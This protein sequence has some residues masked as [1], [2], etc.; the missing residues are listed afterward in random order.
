MRTVAIVGPTASGK[1]ALALEVAKHFD[2]ELVNCDSVQVY[3]NFDIGSAKPTLDDLSVVPHHLIDVCAWDE[4]FDAG[5][6]AN[7]AKDCIKDISSR[8]KLPIIVGGTGLYL[9][10]LLEDKFH[11]QLPKDDEL[12]KKLQLKSKDE[13]IEELKALDPVRCAEIHPNDRVR[14]ERAMEIC[15]ISGRPVSQIFQEPVKKTETPFIVYLNP[16]KGILLDRIRERC[17]DMLKA[18]LVEEVANLIESGVDSQCKPMQSIGYRQANDLLQGNIT[19]DQLEEVIVIA[20]RQYAKKQRTW[21]RTFNVDMTLV[22]VDWYTNREDVL[23]A[24]SGYLE[25]KE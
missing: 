5:Y 15:M 3:K 25:V 12:R 17:R 14:L 6:Y 9:R 4:N 2:G 16:P 22:G 13:L 7:L 20:T 1:S 19:E 10:A 18:G 23:R 21:F 11:S 8:G 24:I